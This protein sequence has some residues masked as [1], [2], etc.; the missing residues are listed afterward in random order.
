M[1]GRFFRYVY[2]QIKL[3]SELITT[4]YHTFLKLAVI[5]YFVII[6]ILSQTREDR[7]ADIVHL[8]LCFYLCTWSRCAGICCSVCSYYWNTLG[9]MCVGLI[10]HRA[11]FVALYWSCLFVGG[12]D[13]TAMSTSSQ[14]NNQKTKT[15]KTLS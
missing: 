14:K 13:A 6:I 12:A 1:A 10:K 5:I 4:I 11:Q 2:I 7:R 8:C 3:N 9:F 15:K